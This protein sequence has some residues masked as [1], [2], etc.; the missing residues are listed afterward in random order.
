VKF[1]IVFFEGYSNILFNYANTV[2][3][4]SY[5]SSDNGSTASV[6]IQA[7]PNLGTQ[8]SYYRPALSSKTSLLWYPSSPTGKGFNQHHRLRLPPD[9]HFDSPSGCHANQRWACASQHF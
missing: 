3:G 6:G 5:S 1:Q 9:R 8:F 4:G 2:F 7:A